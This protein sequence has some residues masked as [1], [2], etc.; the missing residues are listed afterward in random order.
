METIISA[1]IFG[2][3]TKAFFTGK[4]PGADMDKI[5]CIASVDKRH[6][7]MPVQRHTDKVIILD[8]DMEPRV[9]DAVVTRRKDVLI[10]IQA[11]DCTPILLY[12]AKT[13]CIGA[14]HAGWRG[15]AGGIIKNAI[16]EMANF[17]SSPSDILVA[18][19]PCIRWCCYHV[20]YE[21]I[22]AVEKMTGEGNYVT[23]RGGQY[24]L[25]LPSAN[26]CQAMAMG[27]LPENIWMSEECTYC[28]P[29][30]YYSYR[31][32]KGST[33]RQAGFIGAARI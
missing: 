28:L 33:G 29:D 23:E 1:E 12:D 10:G 27:V 13:G 30:K 32:A 7:Y 4:N 17:Y 16:N 22:E 20:G 15:T 6:I 8:S 14:V 9:G 18:V 2:K 3:K 24:C 31:Y 5:A 26:K 25:D 11:A 21:V 19:G